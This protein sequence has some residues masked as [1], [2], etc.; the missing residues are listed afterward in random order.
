VL[1]HIKPYIEEMQSLQGDKGLREIIDNHSKNVLLIEGD[2][3][4]LFDID[5]EKEINI[6]KERGYLIEKD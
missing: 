6:I 3:G 4:N 5:T 2:E 1:V